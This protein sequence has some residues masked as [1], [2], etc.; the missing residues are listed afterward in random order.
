MPVTDWSVGSSE[1]ATSTNQVSRIT[2]LSWPGLTERIASL[3]CAAGTLPVGRK[4]HRETRRSRCLPFLDVAEA[5]PGGAWAQFHGLREVSLPF[6]AIDRVTRDAEPR[7][8][9]VDAEIGVMLIVHSKSPGVCIAGA[10]PGGV[11][12]Q[13]SSSTFET[14]G[15]IALLGRVFIQGNPGSLGVIRRVY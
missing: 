8:D 5:P 6:P 12:P 10:Q 3:H 9:L 14:H 1:R 4:R 2:R 13:R 11:S 7:R 15:P